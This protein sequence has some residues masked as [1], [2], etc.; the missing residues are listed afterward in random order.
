VGEGVVRM[1]QKYDEKNLHWGVTGS[2]LLQIW[3]FDCHTWPGLRARAAPLCKFSCFG[4]SEYRWVLQDLALHGLAK[5][6][7]LIPAE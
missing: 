5:F 4:V 7:D 3:V 2:T 6:A 1:L